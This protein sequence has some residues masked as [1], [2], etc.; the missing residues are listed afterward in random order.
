MSVLRE[1]LGQPALI[2]APGVY[3]TLGAILVEQAGF[4]A[5]YISGAGI[6]YSQ[7]GQPDLGLVY[8]DELISQVARI[9]DRVSIPVI[10][11]GDTGFGG[12]LNVRRLVRALGRLGVQAVQ[13]EDQA[14]PKRCGHLDGKEVV[15][16]EEML[17]RLKAALDSRISDNLL[18]I[19]RTDA[20]AVEG[21]DRALER[22]LRYR[23]VGADVIF[24]EAPPDRQTI[25]TIGRTLGPGPLMANMVE[26]GKTPMLTAEELSALGFRLVIYPNSLTRRFVYVAQQ[27][28]SLIRESGTTI[29][30]TDEMVMFSDLNR[31]LGRS[32]LEAWESRWKDLAVTLKHESMR[33]MP[34][35]EI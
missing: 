31:L 13:L 16:E 14:F 6:A 3:D 23:D 5:V 17:A 26:G 11:D 27:F 25:A 30:A 9:T 34:L 28:L 35:E 4:E 8:P 12:L 18:V 10:V 32:E 7:L 33:R 19:A 22:A 21:L 2:Q 15:P 29:G 1:R 20:L 24:V